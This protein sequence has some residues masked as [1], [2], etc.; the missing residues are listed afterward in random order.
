TVL[1]SVELPG[2]VSTIVGSTVHGGKV[3]LAQWVQNPGDATAQLCTYV[4]RPNG[5][6]I[7][8]VAAATT[9]IPLAT[10]LKTS[11]VQ[12]DKVQGLWM[13]DHR[14]AWFIP[15][16]RRL[17]DYCWRWVYGWYAPNGCP[18][19]D[20]IARRH[21]DSAGWGD[22]VCALVC[23]V[24]VAPQMIITAPDPLSI[25]AGN[26]GGEAMLLATSRAYADN[27]RLFFSSTQKVDNDGADL[28]EASV[29]AGDFSPYDGDDQPTTTRLHVLGFTDD[30][31]LDE[32]DH[33]ALPGTLVGASSADDQGAWILCAKSETGGQASRLVSMAYDGLMVRHRDGQSATFSPSVTDASNGLFLVPDT[34]VKPYRQSQVTG[35]IEALSPWHTDM[36]PALVRISGSA[37]LASA[38][39]WL[40]VARINASRTL[41]PLAAQSWAGYSTQ[42]LSDQAAVDPQ[43]S[44]AWIPAAEYGLEWLGFAANQPA[45]AANAGQ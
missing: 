7:D 17:D 10:V 20:V 29:T 26:A 44:G 9:I 2:S 19:P 14:L 1:D 11:A 27:G 5:N 22:A 45:I 28:D 23:A 15:C 31:C 40:G 16:A 6:K 30:G 21:R 3:F 35:K 38:S 25:R 43:G 18:P 13:G 33:T 4:V 42:L 41:S 12:F 37:V 32:R 8:Q 24:T 34:S 36:C 39:Q